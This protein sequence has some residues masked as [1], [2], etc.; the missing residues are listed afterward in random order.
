MRTAS[1][2]A[3]AR[4]P[5]QRQRTHGWLSRVVTL[6]RRPSAQIP[7]CGCA[8]DEAVPQVHRPLWPGDR[9]F[10]ERDVRGY[11]ATVEDLLPHAKHDRVHPQLETVVEL[12][13]Q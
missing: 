9:R 7:R 5:G 4:R 2:R 6:P 10:E 11:R 13:A 12:L 1:C 3:T 8:I